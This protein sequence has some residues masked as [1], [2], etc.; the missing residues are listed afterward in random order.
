MS[1][2]DENAEV[3]KKAV[4]ACEDYQIMIDI[5]ACSL[6]DL[7]ESLLTNP[8]SQPSQQALRES[9]EKLVKLFSKQLVSKSYIAQI[10]DEPVL[11][12]YPSSEQWLKVVGL[13]SAS[14]EGLLAENINLERLWMMTPEEISEVM[15]RIGAHQSG[16]HILNKALGRLKAWTESQLSGTVGEK[17]HDLFWTEP[18]TNSVRKP[19]PNQPSHRS[20]RLAS[21]GSV[22]RSSTSSTGSDQPAIFGS[23][24][25]NYANQSGTLASQHSS[26]SGHGSGSAVSSPRT[27][28]GSARSPIVIQT[29]STPTLHKGKSRAGT[30]PPQRRNV[31]NSSVFVFP[32]SMQ[33]AAPGVGSPAGSTSGSSSLVIKSISHDSTLTTPGKLNPKSHFGQSV[34][35]DDSMDVSSISSNSNVYTSRSIPVHRI[36][37]RFVTRKFKFGHCDLCKKSLKLLARVCKHCRYKCHRDCERETSMYSCGLSDKLVTEVTRIMEENPLHTYRG[38]PSL[39]SQNSSIQDGFRAFRGSTSIQDSSSASEY[40]YSPSSPLYTAHLTQESP[41]NAGKFTFP[42]ATSLPSG[43]RNMSPSTLESSQLFPTR[44]RDNLTTTVSTIDSED[45]VVAS[46]GTVELNV[47]TQKSEGSDQTVIDSNSSERTLPEQ[48]EISFKGEDDHTPMY[49]QPSLSKALEEWIIPYNELKFGDELGT[50]NLGTVYKYVDI[51]YT[52]YMLCTSMC[53]ILIILYTNSSLC[54]GQWHGDVAIKLIPINPSIDVQS[55]MRAFKQDIVTLKKTRHDNIVLFMGACMKPLAIVTNYV[56]GH[57]LYQDTRTNIKLPLVRITNIA[58]QIIQG[59]AYLHS[60][61]IIHKNLTSKNIFLELEK[62]VITDFGLQSISLA[63]SKSSRGGVMRVPDGWLNY[64]APEIIK[65]L[66]ISNSRELGV[67]LPFSKLSD[68]FAFGTVWYELLCGE[69]PYNHRV[70]A[71]IIIWQVGQGMKPPLHRMNTATKEAKD[72][73]MKCWMYST[74]D[75]PSFAILNTLVEKIPHLAD[76]DHNNTCCSSYNLDLYL[77]LAKYR[78]R[79]KIQD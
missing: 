9:E 16:T 8:T 52:V 47:D 37:H 15:K 78:Q 23:I 38:S 45:T 50:G 69:W 18:S 36:E 27:W 66:R 42:Q 2:S 54:K 79:E 35:A 70:P 63:P 48:L 64:L 58:C 34:S 24:P 29:P 17:Q 43:R 41:A 71:E 55:Q 39:G 76:P 20:T 30:P 4:K 68:V 7:R 60:K 65:A 25:Y 6:Y 3:I 19:N 31:I 77:I 73:L 1:D 5:A 22:P 75:R 74:Q 10:T 44:D 49:R 32:S 62:V 21:T 51:Y 40:S 57:T 56:N 33:S 61:D 72:I 26:S 12:Q 59:M 67:Q 11:D 14:I 46:R 13:P 28:A 53:Y